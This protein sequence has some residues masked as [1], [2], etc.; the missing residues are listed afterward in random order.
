MARSF[1]PQLFRFLRD[2]EENNN[3]E[4]FNQ[5]KDRYEE[6]VREPTLQ[7]VADVAPGL[8]K[9]SKR[10][11]ADPKPV[12]GSMF[13][14]HRDTRFSKDKTPY[15][16]HVGVHFFHESRTEG[17]PVI[18]FHLQPGECFSIAGIH[19]PPTA[20]A[21]EVRAAIAGD[22]AGWKR[23][24]RGGQVPDR[25]SIGEHG[26]LQRVPPEYKDSPVAD[27]LRLKEFMLSTRLTQKEVTADGFVDWYLHL[28]RPALPFLRFVGKAVGVEV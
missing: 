9:L 18:Y 6:H 2:L 16:T 12:S 15:K 10:L 21:R 11:V 8:R 1:G 19:A 5:N 25:F 20:Q 28:M 26:R 24:S 13:R 17:A 22:P 23:V 4:W 27:D 3:R 14:I 7:F